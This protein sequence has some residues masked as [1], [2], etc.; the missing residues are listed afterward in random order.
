M[1]LGCGVI[2]GEYRIRFR[3]NFLIQTLIFM[4]S[5]TYFEPFFVPR[6]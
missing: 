5:F 6:I 2:P 1:G 4:K 3:L